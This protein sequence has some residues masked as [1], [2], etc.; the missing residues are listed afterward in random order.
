MKWYV[1]SFNC[2]LGKVRIGNAPLMTMD[3]SD[4][5]WPEM[6]ED[7]VEYWK[8]R[9][10]N[11]KFV[12]ESNE[13]GI[14]GFFYEPDAGGGLGPPVAACVSAERMQVARG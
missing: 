1:V 4:S 11:L 12:S 10:R 14:V 7:V 6:V 8:N 13:R 3:W 9:G 2:F 5:E